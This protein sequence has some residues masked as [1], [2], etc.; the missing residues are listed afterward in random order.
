MF[1]DEIKE[2]GGEITVIH[3]EGVGHHPHSLKDPQ[4]IVDF[5]LKHVNQSTQ[6]D[7][8]KKARIGAFMHFLP[9]DEASFA[10][11]NDFDV[12]SLAVQLEEMG[13]KYLPL[14][15]IQNDK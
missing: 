10:R 8:L 9:G 15:R 1:Q 3:K 12:V 5:I 13:A 6:T 14:A 4:P 2:L 11:V 7:L